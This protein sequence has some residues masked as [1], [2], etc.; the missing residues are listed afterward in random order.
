MEYERESFSLQIRQNAGKTYRFPRVRDPSRMVGK[1]RRS[2]W[3]PIEWQIK[4]RAHRSSPA[5]FALV[6][7]GGRNVH[8]IGVNLQ[9]RAPTDHHTKIRDGH[10]RAKTGRERFHSRR[11]IQHDCLAYARKILVRGS[12]AGAEHYAALCAG[13]SFSPRGDEIP[14]IRPG[15]YPHPRISRREDLCATAGGHS[16]SSKKRHQG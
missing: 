1:D 10:I 13:L 9:Y 8:R 15:L 4:I 2:S 5:C 6:R 11:R 16:G 12:P 14:T 3:N 7:S